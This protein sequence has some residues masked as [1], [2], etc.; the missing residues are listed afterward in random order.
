MP[1]V[2]DSPVP[3]CV[4]LPCANRPLCSTENN[5]SRAFE[6]VRPALFKFSRIFH[7]V[8]ADR[9][10]LVQD[11]FVR[12]WE[13][14][15]AYDP[16]QMS[17]ANWCKM[18]MCQVVADRCRYVNGKQYPREDLHVDPSSE[19]GV[20]E[21]YFQSPDFSSS[22]LDSAVVH[23]FLDRIDEVNMAILSLKLSEEIEW[24]DIAAI[25]GLNRQTVYDR[26]R[27]MAVV[28]KRI[29]GNTGVE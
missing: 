14:R 28:L 16:A 2:V 11:T 26:R 4:G 23:E 18:L 20:V 24:Q 17:F 22:V 19:D 5:P 12:V 6:E 9:E 3:S 10:D 8:A 15:C 27:Q 1:G 25:L 21:K 13:R 29:M 7:K